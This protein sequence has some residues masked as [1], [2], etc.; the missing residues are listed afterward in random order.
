MVVFGKRSLSLKD[1][2]SHLGLLILGRNILLGLLS[3]DYSSSWNQHTHLTSNSLNSEGK[4]SDIN[5]KKV[6][7]LF[8]GLTSKNTSL[9]CSTIC[10]GLIWVDTFVWIFSIEIVLEKRL[11][12]WDTS[13]STDKHDLVNFCLFKASIF[14]NNI[15]W[16]Q[17]PFEEI[18]TQLLKFS[19]CKGLFKINTIND[20]FDIYLHL[21]HS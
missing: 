8:S 17:S 2:D 12:L 20:T 5:E 9:Y 14:K 10:Y 11:D 7:G 4:W 16:F 18:L 6:L 19:S 3:G 13:G 21:L 1:N 15:D